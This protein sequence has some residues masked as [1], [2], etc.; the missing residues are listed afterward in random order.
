[1]PERAPLK[2]RGVH[3]AFVYVGAG[4]FVSAVLVVGAI[5]GLLVSRGTVNGGDVGPTYIDTGPVPTPEDVLYRRDLFLESTR[6]FDLDRWLYGPEDSA[7]VLFQVDENGPSLVR[8]SLE[9]LVK[10]PTGVV[11]RSLD[12]CAEL[13]SDSEG[14]PQVNAVP[15][16]TGDTVCLRTDEGRVARLVLVAVAST[17][18]VQ[19]EVTVWTPEASITR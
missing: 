4:L 3:S 6:W 8:P 1:M 15:V 17:D 10:A 19:A 11:V 5:P 16:S 12:R 13:L 9:T 18:G 2:G 14:G 7:D